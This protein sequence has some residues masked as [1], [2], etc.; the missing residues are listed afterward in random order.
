MDEQFDE[1]ARNAHE[2]FRDSRLDGFFEQSANVNYRLRLLLSPFRFNTVVMVTMGE[3][4]FHS[5]N[6]LSTCGECTFL[7]T[8][9][10]H[11]QIQEFGCKANKSKININKLI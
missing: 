3:S 7:K 5:N 8:R 11:H 6:F 4:T 10:Y 9:R 1:G 2:K